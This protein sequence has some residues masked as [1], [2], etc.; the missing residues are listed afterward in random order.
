MHVGADTYTVPVLPTGAVGPTPPFG[1]ASWNA[2][3]L[4]VGFTYSSIV[5]PGR[6]PGRIPFETTYSHIETITGSGGPLN[7]TFRDQIELRLYWRP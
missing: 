6:W 7:K 4:G 1:V 3:Q 5:G 2:Q